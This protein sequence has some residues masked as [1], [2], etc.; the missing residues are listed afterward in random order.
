MNSQIK[1]NGIKLNSAFKLNG[2]Q[3]SVLNKLVKFLTS[4]V[5]PGH[6]E[7]YLM[8]LSG[9]A[10]TGKT[11]LLK[12][13]IQ[14]N[15]KLGIKKQRIIG[16]ALTHKARKVLDHTVNKNV[17]MKMETVTVAS[18]LKKQKQAGYVGTKKFRGTGTIIG[19]VDVVLVDEVSMISDRDYADILHWAG[20]YGTKI[21]FIGDSAQI[22]HPIQELIIYDNKLEKRD[23]LAFKLKNTVVLEQVMRQGES[24]PLAE[25][26]LKLR[27]GLREETPY[28]RETKYNLDATGD[29]SG[30]EFV[31]SAV[32]FT[33]R[34]SKYFTE[35]KTVYDGKVICYTN[36]A[37]KQ[38]NDLVRTLRNKRAPIPYDPLEANSEEPFQ[39]GDLLMGYE[40]VG[41]QTKYIQNG[42][43]YEI[44][45][46]RQVND[47][48]ILAD[49]RDLAT[50]ISTGE[51]GHLEAGPY[52]GY[53]LTIVE[54]NRGADADVIKGDKRTI[55]VPDIYSD[56][57]YPV[58]QE[59]I[60]RSDIVNRSGSS[61]EEFKKYK[62]L[63]NQLIFLES[64]YKWSNGQIMGEKDFVTRH[65]LLR[66]RV[67]D[68]IKEEVI[69]DGVSKAI[70]GAK[71]SLKENEIIKELNEKYPGMVVDRLRD[72]NTLGDSEE[73][74][75]RF[76]ILSKDIDYGYAI[77]A[78][79]SQGSTYKYVF[80]DEQDFDKIQ[81]RWNYRHNMMQRGEKERNQLKYVAFTRA[82]CM[83]T[84]L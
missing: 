37:V 20:I 61:I 29:V 70:K 41:F 19:E 17:M 51:P 43:E 55:F 27:K 71:R 22:P 2:E 79:K 54:L 7:T 35:N 34:V 38:Y 52:E 56:L 82:S 10:G 50:R 49:D 72:A 23:S 84:V 44:V 77:T 42:Q 26:Y 16:A 5:V 8:T 80:L 46:V 57:N 45:G 39:I 40:N 13:L 63:K 48:Y 33:E 64:L 78:H 12:L 68:L 4:V 58:L 69:L 3:E 21:L 1:I 75:D 28:K 65:P 59:L 83:V 74:K 30:V 76:Q 15:N 25:I 32:D 53:L 31:D 62:F 18:L 36:R 47:H 66:T 73:L 81:D 6:E 11:S 24:N 67:T 14:Y 9:S 60:K